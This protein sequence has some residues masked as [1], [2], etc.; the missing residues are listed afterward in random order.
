M[1]ELLAVERPLGDLFGTDDDSDGELEP[2]AAPPSADAADDALRRES[3]ALSRLGAVL[4]GL[5]E[6]PPAWLL[7]T[8]TGWGR[9]AGTTWARPSYVACDAA[10]A[11]A[12]PQRGA[13]ADYRWW[14][15]A[16]DATR[17]ASATACPA[18]R[19]RGRSGAVVASAEFAV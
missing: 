15:F 16:D 5:Y 18:A 4:A 9:R 7:R 11:T 14:P 2:A 13:L 3:V 12:R 19:R 6:L 17:A 1:S 10:E 8:Q